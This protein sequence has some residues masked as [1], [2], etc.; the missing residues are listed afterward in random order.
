MPSP[1][2]RSPSFL[3]LFLSYSCLP[4]PSS[5]LIPIFLPFLTPVLL[6]LPPSLFPLYL[7]FPFSLS[8]SSFS[9]IYPHPHRPPP[10][11]PHPPFTL[12][13]IVLQLPF[14][15]FSRPPLSTP[16]S[17]SLPLPFPSFF[18]TLIV[19]HLPLL[20]PF[21]F[22][23][24]LPFPS[25]LFFLPLH[26]ISSFSFSPPHPYLLPPSLPHPLYFPLPSPSPLT[27]LLSSSP[28]FFFLI[29]PSFPLL[30]PSPPFPFDSL[31]LPM[32]GTHV[33]LMPECGT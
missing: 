31:A 17:S 26:Y 27:P 3:P 20:I 16:L 11:L 9:L 6:C 32:A 5:P 29:P 1:S 7:Y 4:S 24:L 10:S 19:L 18:L 33:A 28:F 14:P 2:H 15:P 12:T 13:L 23:S 30:S 22:S 25:L 21:I 8:S